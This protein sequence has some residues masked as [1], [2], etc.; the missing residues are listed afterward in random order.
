M[1]INKFQEFIKGIL[2]F[3]LY[4][5]ASLT[6]ELIIVSVKPSTTLG[7]TILPLA[8]QLIFVGILIIIFRKTLIEDF[9]KLKVNFKENFRTTIKYWLLGL[10]VMYVGNFIATFI[11]NNGAIAANQTN[12]DEILG[13]APVYYVFFVAI[14]GPFIEE[15]IFRAGFR[16]AFSKP[17]SYAIFCGLLFG[18]M[19]LIAGLDFSS[20]S[21][22]LAS[23][24]EFAFLIS[25]GAL[26]FS[27]A[28]IYFKTDNIY[29][30]V[31]AHV[32]HNT[33]SLLLMLIAHLGGIA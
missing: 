9:K 10:L 15:L 12:V 20:L 4:F 17:I 30:P 3:I 8:L 2:I 23:S 29:F 11:V 18:S 33:L 6:I 25:Y 1:K 7:N 24:K 27:F 26:G 16:K 5:A 19:H 14:L 21:A 13:S 22:F 28:F 32:L 31:I